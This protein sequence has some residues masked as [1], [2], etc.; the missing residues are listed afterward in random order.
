MTR[1]TV[2]TLLE[3]I[4]LRR[5]ITKGT[6]DRLVLSYSDYSG[7]TEPWHRNFVEGIRGF[8]RDGMKVEIEVEG[9]MMDYEWLRGGCDDLS[10]SS[11]LSSR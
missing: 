7:I 5:T 1:F 8:V 10:T 9:E 2:E 4:H 11:R 6:L 3:M